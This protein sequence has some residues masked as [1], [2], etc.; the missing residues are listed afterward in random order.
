MD[1]L[2]KRAGV[3]AL[4]LI[5]SA[6]TALGFGLLR[7]ASS[8]DRADVSGGKHE[9]PDLVAAIQLPD[10]VVTTFEG[11]TPLV[12]PPK[13][14]VQPS[15]SAVKTSAVLVNRP[16]RALAP[17]RV[18][19]TPKPSAA[20]A[21][22]PKEPVLDGLDVGLGLQA[23][24]RELDDRGSK[25]FAIRQLGGTEQLRKPRLGGERITFETDLGRP[26]R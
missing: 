17:L 13:A 2:A 24:R 4:V 14:A 19:A 1:K 9:P 21:E 25:A 6:G 11:E 15:R 20:E 18:A 8:L 12:T 22:R 3:T 5:A 23:S 16:K 10:A 7:M 26:D